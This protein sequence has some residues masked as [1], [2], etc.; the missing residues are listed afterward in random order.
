MEPSPRHA[1]GVQNQVSHLEVERLT[2]GEE[3]LEHLERLLL[4]PRTFDT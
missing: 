4:Q 1:V 2:S 3:L